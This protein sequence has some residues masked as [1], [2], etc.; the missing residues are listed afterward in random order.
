MKLFSAQLIPFYTWLDSARDAVLT[1]STRAYCLLN[2]KQLDWRYF[3]DTLFDRKE[4][5][6][7]FVDIYESHDPKKKKPLV[8]LHK[9]IDATYSLHKSFAARHKTRIQ[10]Y[11]D[12]LANKGQRIK[13]SVAFTEGLVDSL[14]NKI[15]GST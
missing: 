15:G 6:K 3:R 13:S 12:D 14:T 8:T 4:A 1:G 11:R 9:D 5:N 10:I 2:A 7:T